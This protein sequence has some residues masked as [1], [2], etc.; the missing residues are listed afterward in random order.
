MVFQEFR[1]VPH[2][3]AFD[4]VALPLRIAGAPERDISKP[5]RD[6]LAVDVTG[7]KAF[8]QAAGFLRIRDSAQGAK[9]PVLQA[10]PLARALYAHCDVDQE[11][12]ARLFGAVA[13]VLP[14]H[15]RE[16]HGSLGEEALILGGAVGN[17]IDRVRIGEVIDFVDV[18]WGRY[19]WPA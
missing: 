6:M 1:L 2:L 18:Y 17:L 5:V 13:Q 4:N 7:P 12:P 8:E 15:P 9:V 11:V 14:L 10:P 16:G 19:H 3:S